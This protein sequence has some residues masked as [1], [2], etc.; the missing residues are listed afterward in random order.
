LA[1]VA[2]VQAGQYPGISQPG[3]GAQQRYGIVIGTVPAL[4]ELIVKLVVYRDR[5]DFIHDV[6]Q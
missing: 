1:A 3:L 2:F 6:F 5:S 4:T